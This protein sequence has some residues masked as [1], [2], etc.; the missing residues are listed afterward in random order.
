MA[1]DKLTVPKGITHCFHN[2]TDQIVTVFN[3][4]QPAFR[5]EQ[6]FEELCTVLDQLTHHGSRPLKMNLTTKLYMSVMMN[7]YRHEI[8]AKNPRI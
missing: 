4:H 6:Y 1:G 8:I 5:M 7:R 3:T 2:P